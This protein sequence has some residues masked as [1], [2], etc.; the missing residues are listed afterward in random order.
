MS[1]EIRIKCAEAM[2]WNGIRIRHAT[3]AHIGIL[4][5]SHENTCGTLQAI[6]NYT[7]SVDAAMELVEWMKK[8]KGK[9]FRLTWY[10]E[11][12][13]AAFFGNDAF[14]ANS[15]SPALAICKAFLDA[16]QQ[17]PQGCTTEKPV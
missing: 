4:T 2:G 15:D 9:C 12:W 8:N 6:P 1:D 10:D 3:R 16:N 17:T 14:H 11:S 5:G 13:S 7:Q